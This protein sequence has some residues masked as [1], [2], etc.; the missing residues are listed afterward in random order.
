MEVTLFHLILVLT[1]L[2][3]FTVNSFL[4]AFASMILKK[5]KDIPLI[6]MIASIEYLGPLPIIIDLVYSKLYGYGLIETKAGCNLSGAMTSFVY[7]FEIVL[8]AFLAV[9]RLSLFIK[10][11]IVKVL[12]YYLAISCLLF[13]S[14][15]VGSASTNGFIPTLTDFTCVLNITDSILSIFTYFYLMVTTTINLIIIIGCYHYITK[16]VNGTQEFVNLSSFGNE[17]FKYRSKIFQNAVTKIYI[18]LFLYGIAMICS[19][20]FFLLQGIFLYP[21]VI[22]NKHYST[23]SYYTATLAFL[24][25]IIMN[26]IVILTTHTG[27]AIES[28]KAFRSF[29]N[30]FLKK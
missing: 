7:F 3:A 10:S 30:L 11:R 5:T 26:S 20:I 6:I 19:T 18:T 14:L 29:K 8:S 15:L 2:V 9:E 23:I 4:I 13:M 21:S 24:I 17:A 12:F 22:Q 27:V 28:R 25:G 16:K 1:T